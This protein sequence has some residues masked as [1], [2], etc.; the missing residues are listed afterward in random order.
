MYA[1]FVD[2][3]RKI[4]AV[5]FAICGL[6]WVVCENL[7]VNPWAGIF[8]II[9]I[10]CFFAAIGLVAEY[11]VRS[12]LEV[13]PKGLQ[14]YQFSLLEMFAAVT[15]FGVLLSCYKILGDAVWP[16]GIVFLAIVAC[17]IEAR[18]RSSA[19]DAQDPLA[20]APDPR[21]RPPNRTTSDAE[22]TMRENE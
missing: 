18:R 15:L 4:V 10:A 1:T 9:T 8:M 17:I 2:N 20:D 22:S 3:L 6:G 11:L 14:K 7:H 5:V 19:A 12:F 13:R 21:S 16:L